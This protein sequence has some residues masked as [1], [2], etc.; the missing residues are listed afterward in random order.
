MKKIKGTVAALLIASMALS[1]AACGSVKE[2]APKDF[3]SIVKE[4][5]DCDKDDIDESDGYDYIESRLRYK[6]E[7]SD[8]YDITLTEYE[9]EEA[10]QYMFDSRVTSM[11]FL[12]DH[13]GIDGKSKIAKNYITY[14]AEITYSYDGD[15][16]DAYGGCYLANNYIIEIEATTGKD[17]DKDVIDDLLK[18]LGYPRPSRA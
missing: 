7:D 9:D 4:V 6:G 11:Q 10:A 8:K 17:K 13:N 2:V 16:T 14:D 1:I 5:L 15:S 18:E 12:K 3:K